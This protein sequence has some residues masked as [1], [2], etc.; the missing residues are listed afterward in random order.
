MEKGK[1]TSCTTLGVGLHQEGM[2]Q[3]WKDGKG[4]NDVVRGIG[5]GLCLT[6]MVTDCDIR[7]EDLCWVEQP[8]IRPAPHPPPHP[9]ARPRAP[10]TSPVT[11]FQ[12]FCVG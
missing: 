1:M 3:R 2:W 5:R 11:A 7:R 9:P 10:P 4:E 8:P 12:Y 6:T